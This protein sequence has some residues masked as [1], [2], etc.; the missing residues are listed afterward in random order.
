MN[1]A[2][3]KHWNS[4][5]TIEQAGLSEYPGLAQLAYIPATSVDARIAV[6]L[7]AQR[8]LIIRLL[9]RRP[10]RSRNV[11]DMKID[12]NLRHKNNRWMIEFRIDELNVGRDCGQP[13]VYRMLFP[14]DLAPQLEEFLTVWRPMLPGSNRLE[15]FTTR[16]GRSFTGCALNN[17]VRKNI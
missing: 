14:E 5:A 10:L 13:S 16:T 11:C 15:L 3:R 12:H 8:S 9:V 1:R 2:P 17:G 4:L 7:K 6:A